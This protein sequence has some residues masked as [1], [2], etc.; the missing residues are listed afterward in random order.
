MIIQG[1]G[2]PFIP[3][4]IDPQGPGPT[5]DSY[6]DSICHRTQAYT[7]DQFE[8]TPPDVVFTGEFSDKGIDWNANGLYDELQVEIGVEVLRGGFFAIHWTL[9]NND[10]SSAIAETDDEIYLDAGKQTISTRFTG[11]VIRDSGIDG[12]YNV[13]VNILRV[14]RPRDPEANF[15][16]SFYA[17]DQFER[18]DNSNDTRLIWLES[19]DVRAAG[20]PPDLQGAGV[21]TVRRGSD[22]MDVVTDGTVQL[23]IRDSNGNSVFVGLV[24]I[25][26]PSG[27]GSVA[28]SFTFSLPSHGDYIATAELYSVWSLPS[29]DTMEV[30]FQA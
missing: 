26:I 25:S 20:E 16:T 19:L 17:H 27:G 8:E 13:H 14:Q 23:T 22:L 3:A 29:P 12:P 10:G 24:N 30:S 28:A 11:G 21:V 4:P 6:G 7:H 15:T 2:L 1:P 5:Y 9:S 18:Y